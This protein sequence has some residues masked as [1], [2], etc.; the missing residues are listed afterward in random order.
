MITNYEHALRTQ[1]RRFE[2]NKE[3][4]C[5]AV[6]R[7]LDREHP[8]DIQLKNKLLREADSAANPIFEEDLG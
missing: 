3:G 4:I 1:T 8:N 5:K 7:Y 2:K 6:Q